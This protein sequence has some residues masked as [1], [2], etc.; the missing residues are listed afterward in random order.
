MEQDKITVGWREWVA[1][2]DLGIK[3]VKAKLDT[4]ARTSSLHTFYLEPF[5]QDGRLQV[6]FGIHPLQRRE[7]IGVNCIADV[8]DYRRVT[9]S[10]G[11]SEKRFFILTNV[12]LKG[13][14]W[15][16]EI[17]LANRESMRFRMLLGRAAISGRLLVDP[18]KS[19]LSGR[20]LSKL[21][22]K[23]PKRK[24]IS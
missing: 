24:A 23:G 13:S 18:E 17:S 5:E 12:A 1:L 22:S 15:P 21:Y 20:R 10:D 11:Q 4:G 19:Y 3:A 9:S 2:P 6:K 14:I 8:S 7:D 16:V